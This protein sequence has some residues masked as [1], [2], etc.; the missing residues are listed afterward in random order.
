M[1]NRVEVFIP[2]KYLIVDVAKA[3]YKLAEA[4]NLDITLR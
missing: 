4:E 1:K 3:N 2:F